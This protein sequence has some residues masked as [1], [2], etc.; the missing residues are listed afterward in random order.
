MSEDAWRTLQIDKD[1]FDFY[2]EELPEETE[3]LLKELEIPMYGP[4]IEPVSNP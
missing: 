3:D 1:E 4:K 2:K